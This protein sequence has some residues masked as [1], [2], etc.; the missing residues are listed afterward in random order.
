MKIVKPFLCSVFTVLA[1]SLVACNSTNEVAGNTVKTSENNKYNLLFIMVD[2]MR[3][4]AMSRAG[5]TV[6]QTPNID[7]LAR[8]GVAF[9]NAY[10][11][12]AVCGPARSAVLTGHTA[13]N[14]GVNTNEKTYEYNKTEVMTQPTFDEIL[15]NQ[16]YHAEY[17]GKWHSMTKHTKVYKNPVL[18][19]EKG[20]SIFLQG[21]QKFMYIDYL[22]ANVPMVQ[23]KAGQGWD[24][25][26]ERSYTKSP[27]DKRYGK[28]YHRS[29]RREFQLRQPDLHG[30]SVIPAEHSFT[31]FQSKQVINAIERL[32]DKPFSIQLNLHFPHA[33]ML[34]VEPY[35]SM[36]KAEDM[37]VPASIA[38]TMENSP[39]IGANGRKN[40]TDYRDPAKV[41]HMTAA[42]YALIHELDDWMGKIFAKL[43][44][45]NL[46][47]K[48]LIIFTSDHGEML[49]AHGMREKNVFYEESAHIPL[50]VRLPQAIKQNIE[51]EGSVSTLD[52]FST[53]LDY[54]NMGQ[55]PSDGKSLRGLIE[56]TDKEHGEY[57]VT[58][59]DYN[60]PSQ[61]NYMVVKNGWKLMVPYSKDS[62]IVSVLYDLNTD[63]HEMNNLIGR[64]PNKQ[65]NNVEKALELRS[66][67]L[68]WLQQRNSKRVQGVAA[69][70][71]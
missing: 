10:T 51:V 5:N 55:H 66:D 41:Q 21:G 63:P 57:V 42:Y 2:Q 17:Y 1:C 53:I 60:G 54:L 39:Y 19:S 49:G 35:A 64:N 27:M 65:A 43:D 47:E 16:G 32:K 8:E 69:L 20:R 23:P 67:L 31:A 52:L 7:K 11:T 13:E 58:E 50:L 25:L 30:V 9:N 36:Y 71:F 6:L 28:P 70:A 18:A 29:D 56:G 12:V 4:D 59:W 40:L 37:P 26:T 61:P 34:P 68:T 14:T 48:T 46:T 38:D 22:N 33:P 45:H 62:S 15:T 24:P 3:F 44:E